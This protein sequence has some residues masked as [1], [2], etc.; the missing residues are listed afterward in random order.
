M[1]TIPYTFQRAI[2]GIDVI[3][4]LECELEC[5]VEISGG[6][7][8]VTVVSVTGFSGSD[9][10]LALLLAR[11]IITAAQADKEVWD[12]AIAAADISYRGLGPNDPDGQYV[13]AA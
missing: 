9:D 5:T 8:E 12:D 1:T 10:A 13:R 2:N 3:V 7:P 4:D 6:E 11:E